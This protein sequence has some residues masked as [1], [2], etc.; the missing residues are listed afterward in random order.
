[1]NVSNRN[2]DFVDEGF[3]LAIRL[4]EPKDN[5]LVARKLEDATLGVLQHLPT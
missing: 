4:G 1:L 5:R 3:D 2:I